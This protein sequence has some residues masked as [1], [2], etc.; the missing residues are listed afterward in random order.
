MNRIWTSLQRACLVASLAAGL[1]CASNP[2]SRSTGEYVDDKVVS[3]K[4]KAALVGDPTTKAYQIG[5]STF[6]GVVQLSGFVD[7]SEQVDRAT[8]VAQEVDGVKSVDNE[9]KVR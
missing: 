2:S 6:D 3:A 7:S 1:A 9:L 4:V 8:Q 5:V